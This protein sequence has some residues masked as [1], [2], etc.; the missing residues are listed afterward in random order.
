MAE[1]NEFFEEF[2]RSSATLSQMSVLDTTGQ[3]RI[4]NDPVHGHVSIP[5]Y[6]YEVIDTPQF[7]RLRDLKQLGT[8]YF[9]F[10]GA[11]HNRFEHSLGVCYLAGKFVNTLRKKQPELLITDED[12]KLVSL[13]GLCHDLGH[14]PFSHAFENWA[15]R[16]GV[17]FHHEEMSKDLLQLLVDD[18]HLDYTKEEIGFIQDLIGGKPHAS[19]EKR[20]L[21]D[22]VANSRTSVDVDKFDY[23]A[24][25]CINVGMKNSYDHSRLMKFSRVIN[26]EICFLS[27]EVYNVYEMFHTRYSMHKLVYSHKVAKAIEFMI[28][29]AISA[30]NVH[31]KIS[32]RIQDPKRYVYL[33]DGILKD[34]EASED[35]ALSASRAIVQRIRRRELYKMADE[36]L[37]PAD[38]QRRRHTPLELSDAEISKAVV[39][40]SRTLQIED[41]IIDRVKMNYAMK[42]QNPVDSVHFFSKWDATES[43]SIPKQKVSLL[44]PE[45]FSENYVRVFVRRPEQAF[46]AQEAFRKLFHMC[47]PSPAHSLPSPSQK[48][49]PGVDLTGKKKRKLFA[50]DDSGL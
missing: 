22:I 17:P 50:E 8:S 5:K 4:I 27:K 25:D 24:R 15:A 48:P 6:C 40:L 34:I 19:Q 12:I 35:P 13:A 29:D 44:I 20:F 42:D 41:I 46:D 30:A 28:F 32:E 26:N 33:T 38:P 43:F 18:N 14:G 31:L 16:C 11:S 45:Q 2:D 21:F 7:Q 3:S 36:I 10:P 1:T 39:S 23:L 47:D 49:N 37:V 9:V